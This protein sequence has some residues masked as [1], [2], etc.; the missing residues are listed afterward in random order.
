MHKGSLGLELVDHGHR[1]SG[2]LIKNASGQ[3]VRK[4]TLRLLLPSP[5]LLPCSGVVSGS[6]LLFVNGQNICNVHSLV[7]SPAC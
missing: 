3:A 5:N 1:D 6:T 7:N 2:L 4:G